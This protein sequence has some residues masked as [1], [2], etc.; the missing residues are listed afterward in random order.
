MSEWKRI[1]DEM[2]PA[3]VPV[4]CYGSDEYYSKRTGMCVLKWDKDIGEIWWEMPFMGG[5]EAECD[6]RKPTHWMPLPSPPDQPKATP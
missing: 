6:M 3:G 2:P 5:Q 4:L 1:A